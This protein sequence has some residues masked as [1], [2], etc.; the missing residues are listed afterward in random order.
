MQNSTS[1]NSLGRDRS[2]SKDSMSKQYHFLN[3]TFGTNHEQQR[4]IYYKELERGLV[5]ESGP[6]PAAYDYSINSIRN[7]GVSIPKAERFKEFRELNN[8]SPGIG[9]YD[10]AKSSISVKK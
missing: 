6:G 5:N 4:R 1:N 10:I 9:S 7:Q 8:N 3:S 2:L